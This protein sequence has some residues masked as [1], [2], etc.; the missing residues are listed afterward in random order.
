MRFIPLAALAVCLYACNDKTGSSTYRLTETAIFNT[1]SV[2]AALTGKEAKNS[3]AEKK[4]LAAL[5]M[6]RNKK[7][8]VQSIPLFY[9]SI[10]KQPQA[11][12]YYELG[13]AL[14][15]AAK[16]PEAV[17]AYEVAEY[18]DYKPMYKLL[19]NKACAYSKQKK[20]DE[21][22]ENLI[23]AI[24]FGYSNLNNIMKDPDLE[25]VRSMRDDFREVV[26]L[27]LSGATDPDKLQWISFYR[28]FKTA[29]MP[30]TLD[31]SYA[32]KLN[33]YYI[34]Y[35]FENYVSEMK[36]AQF[37]RET[38]STFYY[39][40]I[41]KSDSAYKTL[42]YAINDKELDNY[43]W[44]YYMLASYNSSGKLIEKMLV[45]GQAKDEDPYRVAVFNANGEFNIRQYEI[46][47]EKN[48][49]EEGFNNNKEV[50]STVVATDYYSIGADGHFIHKQNEPLASR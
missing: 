10:L 18:L 33:D 45:A 11:K 35:D 17:Q 43:Q 13:N 41:V 32:A 31:K 34:P 46:E 14:I 37:S 20:N 47:Y 49:K 5:D 28:E 40:G 6:Y 1:D 26:R 24:E 2:H 29:Q 36:G 39:V 25:Y 16:F 44:P 27:A 9:E 21:A 23:S 15:D 4:F 7:S 12:A 3:E 50:K 19:Y 38:G 30:L 8:A 48:P 22:M 42:V